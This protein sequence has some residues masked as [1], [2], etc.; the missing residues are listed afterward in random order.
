MHR[1]QHAAPGT[2]PRH[3]VPVLCT[4]YENGKSLPAT[5]SQQNSTTKSTIKLYFKSIALQ[6]DAVK[7]I[8][9]GGEMSA[10]VMG[11]WELACLVEGE[12]K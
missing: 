3:L 12:L 10:V 1:H 4:T 2:V 11:N 9:D 7:G 8:I 6:K 5:I